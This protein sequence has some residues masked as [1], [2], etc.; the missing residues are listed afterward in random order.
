MLCSFGYGDGGGGPTAEMLETQRRLAY[1]IPGCPTTKPA[2]AREFFDKLAADVAEKNV[3]IWSGELYLEYHRAT[4]TSMARN[5]RSNRRGEF[6]LLNLEAWASAAILLCG[7]EYPSAAL[8]EGWEILMRN[9]FHDILPGSSIRQV[10]ED[11]K[12][13]YARLSQL[14]MEETDKRLQQLTDRIGGTVVWNP[15]GQS[16][17]VCLPSVNCKSAT[18]RSSRPL[19]ICV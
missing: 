12:R 4:Y 19:R 10:Y 2:T 5:K 11:S 7:T 16:A 1:G 15:N 13:E 14:T 18:G 17:T 9:Q 6:A 8:Q 3:P